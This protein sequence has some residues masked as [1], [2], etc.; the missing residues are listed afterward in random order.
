MKPHPNKIKQED[1]PPNKKYFKLALVLSSEFLFI[2]ARIYTA[3][4]CNSILRYILIKSELANNKEPPKVVKSKIKE[5]SDIIGPDNNFSILLLLI[6]SLG[7]QGIS[8]KAPKKKRKLSI[9]R[10]NGVT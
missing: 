2:E 5:Y 4:D 3:K 10:I 1:K 9:N 7:Y 8:I 6:V